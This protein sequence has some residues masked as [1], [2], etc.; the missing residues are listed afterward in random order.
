MVSHKT[1][2]QPQKGTVFYSLVYALAALAGQ[3]TLYKSIDL[4]AESKNASIAYPLSVG[5][6]ITVFSL[7]S[8]CVLKENIGK[9]GKTGLAL[10]II[11]IFLIALN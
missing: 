4:L 7:Y 5:I 6:C 8:L 3:V 1:T 9:S 2:S 11:G 10:I